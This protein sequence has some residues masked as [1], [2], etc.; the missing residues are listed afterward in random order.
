[1][2]FTTAPLH[3]KEY[4]QII[5]LLDDE[6]KLAYL[7]DS[8]TPLWSIVPDGVPKALWAI[9][10]EGELVGAAGYVVAETQRDLASVGLIVAPA[11]RRQGIGS[12]VMSK[13]LDLLDQHGTRRL[14]TKLYVEQVDGQRFLA[15]RGFHVWGGSIVGQLE[16][17]SAQM[18]TLG[19]PDEWVNKQGL[20]FV[21]L[22]RLPRRG[23]AQR[24]LP[25]WNR[26]RPDQPQDWPYPTYAADRFEQEMLEPGEVALHHSYALLT[27]SQQVVAL[28]L[29]MQV[30]VPHTASHLFT[31]YSAVD[32]ELRRRKLATALKAKLIAHAQAHGIDTLSSENDLRNIGMWQINQSLGYRGLTELITYHKIK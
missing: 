19:D 12:H 4:Q 22:D 24:L 14:L 17:A 2:K 9:K 16:V 1:M 8:F 6:K 31:I 5:K 7:P 3:R 13:L 30:V 25:I 10:R 26:T 11:Y 20:H 29:N 32:P 28:S 15:S 23:L 21:T 27:T 18:N